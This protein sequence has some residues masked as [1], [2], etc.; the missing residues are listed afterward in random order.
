MSKITTQKGPTARDI[1]IIFCVVV[2]VLAAGGFIYRTWS[3]D[4]PQI[5]NAKVQVP[6][7]AAKLQAMKAQQAGQDASNSGGAG[8]AGQDIPLNN[9]KPAGTGQ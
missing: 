2:A 9:S 6:G 1:G 4:Q 8:G 7:S 3:Q 5:Q